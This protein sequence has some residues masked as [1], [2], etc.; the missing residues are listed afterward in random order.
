MCDTA[1]ITPGLTYFPAA[2][3]I[4]APAG[5]VTLAPTATIF[6][7]RMTTVPLRIA[8]PV[9]GITVPPR[10]AIARSW[11]EAD[12]EKTR[13]A[14]AAVGDARDL[15]GIQGHHLECFVLGN[16]VAHRQRGTELKPLLADD[17]ASVCIAILTPV[18]PNACRC[19]WR[20]PCA[21]AAH[22]GR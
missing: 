10:I 17:R 12:A 9:I 16:P 13:K 19:L 15:H 2:S 8:G 6:P 14:V 4:S 7:P 3:T 5:T 18:V 11:A 1:S 21:P 20:G 22:A